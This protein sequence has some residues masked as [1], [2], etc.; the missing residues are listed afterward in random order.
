MEYSRELIESN[1]GELQSMEAMGEFPLNVVQNLNGNT[2]YRRTDGDPMHWDCESPPKS[3]YLLHWHDAFEKVTMYQGELVFLVR[4]ADGFVKKIVI[5]AGQSLIL[6]IGEKHIV[7]NPS[8]A[9]TAKYHVIFS[10][11]KDNFV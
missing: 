11:D 9:V 10:F 2:C 6:P 1:F 5:T 7:K 8:D 3:S 4:Q